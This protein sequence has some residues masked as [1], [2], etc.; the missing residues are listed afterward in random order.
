M[1]QL[2]GAVRRGLGAL[3]GNRVEKVEWKVRPNDF[4]TSIRQL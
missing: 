3:D 1:Y 2:V 4:G